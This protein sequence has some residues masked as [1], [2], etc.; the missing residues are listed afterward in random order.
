MKSKEMLERSPGCDK[1]ELCN[2]AQLAIPEPQA[3][4]DASTSQENSTGRG[5]RS[6]RTSFWAVLLLW[7]LPALG[8]L[9]QGLPNPFL[10]KDINQTRS[11]GYITEFKLLRTNIIFTAYQESSGYELWKS[12]GT[13]SGTVLTI[14]RWTRRMAACGSVPAT[15]CCI[16]AIIGSS[17][18]RRKGG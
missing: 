11:G 15:A 10:L 9:S 8:M 6:A 1:G 14:W 16:T 5:S 3:A 17:A 7:M 4:V 12:D 18:M 13:V 2:R